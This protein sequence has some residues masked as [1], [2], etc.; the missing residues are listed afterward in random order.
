M[1]SIPY[2][3][4]IPDAPNN[5]STDQPNMKINTNAVSTILAVDHHTFSDSNAGTHLQVTFPAATS[6]VPT[7]SSTTGVLYSALDSNSASQLFF[8]NKSTTYQLTGTTSTDFT[9]GSL[10]DG[11]SYSVLTLAFGIRIFMGQTA[12]ASGSRT[13]TM[14]ASTFGSTIY[15]AQATVFGASSIATSITPNANLA[16]FNIQ[17]ANT[18]PIYFLIITN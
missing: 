6:P 13:L 16:T 14:S 9:S 3:L 1:P 4:D 15:T 10:S 18:A 11:G 5:P 7:A 17:S 12:S 8:V 2:N